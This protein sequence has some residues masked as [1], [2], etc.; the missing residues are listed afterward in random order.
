MSLHLLKTKLTLEAFLGPIIYSPERRFIW[1][2]L[3]YVNI[4]RNPDN[5]TT[6]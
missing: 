6:G 2:F 3:N 5:A 1:H 4:E